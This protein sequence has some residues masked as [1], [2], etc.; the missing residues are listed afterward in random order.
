MKH[1]PFRSTLTAAVLGLLAAPSAFAVALTP[2][3]SD[4]VEPSDGWSTP[5][6][7]W[8]ASLKGLTPS[9]GSRFWG[10]A[11]NVPASI[12]LSKSFAGLTV[13]PGTYRLL[14]DVADPHAA[15]ADPVPYANFTT[16]GLTGIASPADIESAPTPPGGVPQWTTWALTYTVPEG[17]PDTGNTLGFAMAYNNPA[18]TSYGVMLDN[19][20]IE[21]A[22]VPEPTSLAILALGAAT[23]TR[24]RRGMNNA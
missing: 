15:N 16:F 21:F 20:R 22:P 14:I 4:P 6:I 3:Y 17:S 23:L 18:N 1:H 7:H 13:E 9:A 12:G 24:R 19:L 2:L 5:S 11:S 8:T 10:S